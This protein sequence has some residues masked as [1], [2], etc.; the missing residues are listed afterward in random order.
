MTEVVV[1]K[2]TVE[3]STLTS[4]ATSATFNCTLTVVVVAETTSTPVTL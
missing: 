2:M 3:A 4:L 1:C